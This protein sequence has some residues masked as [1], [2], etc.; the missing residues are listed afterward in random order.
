MVLDKGAKGR[1]VFVSLRPT[2]S[3]QYTPGQP[4]LKS[5]RLSKKKKKIS[6]SDKIQT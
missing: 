3:I 5:E 6:I 4:E 1:V 2:W